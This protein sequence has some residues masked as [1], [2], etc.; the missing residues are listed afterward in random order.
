MIKRLF[1]TSFTIKRMEYTADK[2]TLVTQGTFFGHIQQTSPEKAAQ[3][4]GSFKISHS[5]WCEIGT[6]VEIGDVLENG[7]DKYI[8]KAIQ[9]NNIGYN[10]HLQL[11]VEK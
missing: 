8:I 2:S 11:Y 3:L 1:K 7:T 4:A 9:S 6:D 10:K 5:I